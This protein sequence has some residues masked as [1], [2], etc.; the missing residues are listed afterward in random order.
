MMCYWCFQ[1][2]Q[3]PRWLG[4]RHRERRGGAAMLPNWREMC[5]VGAGG[6][7]VAVVLLGKYSPSQAS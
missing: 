7:L 4:A 2:G 6:Q 3:N 1:A 5:D